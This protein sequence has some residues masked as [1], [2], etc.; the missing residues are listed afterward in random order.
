M[1]GHLC[2]S[3]CLGDVT[4]GQSPDPPKRLQAV[5]FVADPSG[6]TRGARHVDCARA[7]TT[8][9]SRSYA[10]RM[11]LV[12]LDSGLGG[13]RE[14]TGGGRKVRWTVELTRT[15]DDLI[16][17][18]S[19]HLLELTTSVYSSAEC[20]NDDL[21]NSRARAQVESVSPS[22]EPQQR[23]RAACRSHYWYCNS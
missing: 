23:Y 10:G 11:T 17:A 21:V 8:S 18:L 19:R 5:P 14:V 12:D 7:D 13:A 9:L 20:S 2:H 22:R 3:L 16:Y 15:T 1:A 6:L 4:V